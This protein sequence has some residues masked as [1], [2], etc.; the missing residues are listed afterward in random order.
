MTLVD[1]YLGAVRDNLPRAQR[2]DIIE[3]L[4]DSLRSRLEDWALTAAILRACPSI[5]RS[6]RVARPYMSSIRAR[7]ARHR[8]RFSARRARALRE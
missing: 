1:R 3:E 7:S 8:R 5:L 4:E 6:N 2:D